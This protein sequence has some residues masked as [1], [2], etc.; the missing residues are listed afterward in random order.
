CLQEIKLVSLLEVDEAPQTNKGKE[1]GE[2]GIPDGR[3]DRHTDEWM[4][5]DDVLT[6]Q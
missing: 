1:K 5:A 4:R 2:V 3:G 6:S